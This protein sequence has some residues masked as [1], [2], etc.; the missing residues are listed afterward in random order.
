MQITE[1]TI[2]SLRYIMKSSDGE[3]IENI[4]AG[5]AVKYLHG[6][7]EILPEL[8]AS[9]AGLKPGDKKSIALELPDIFHFDF[10]IDE[11]RMATA[12]EIN[13]GKPLTAN[14]CGPDC[15]C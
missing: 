2:V 11:V 6:S 5:P 12:D 8:E 1:K 15:C 4:I 7:G 13:S 10:E 9:L 3:E 14:A